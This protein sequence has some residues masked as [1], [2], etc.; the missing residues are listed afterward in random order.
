MDA[1]GPRRE[2]RWCTF[3]SLAHLIW[4]SIA[5][6]SR[7]GGVLCVSY[8]VSSAGYGP[9]GDVH[10]LC[11]LKRVQTLNCARCLVAVSFQVGDQLALTR[12][13]LLALCDGP[14]RCA[15]SS[16]M[17]TRFALKTCESS[18]LP[19]RRQSHSTGKTGAEKALCR[20]SIL[21]MSVG[22]SLS[23]SDSNPPQW[24][25]HLDTL[26]TCCA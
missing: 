26:A 9:V 15:R 4:R 24:K 17:R 11:L 2:C 20:N 21:Y 16:T 6:Y 12:E 1:I 22:A 13:M 23:N 3:Q 10:G 25:V 19:G 18:K 5:R 14:I 7:I 8:S